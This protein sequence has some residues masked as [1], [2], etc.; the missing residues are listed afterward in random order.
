MVSKGRRAVD[1]PRLNTT[2]ASCTT[3]ARECRRTTGRRRSELR[4]AA[5]Q[6]DASAQYNLGVMYANGEGVPEDYVKAYAWINLA[7]AQGQKDVVKAKD[8]IRE[9][10]TTEQVAGSP[11][12]LRRALQAHRIRKFKVNSPW[13]SDNSQYVNFQRRKIMTNRNAR[14]GQLAFLLLAFACLAMFQPTDAARSK[15]SI[16]SAK[17][18]RREMPRHK[19]SWVSC[20]PRARGCRRTTKRR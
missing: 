7:A 9:K 13:T 5:E 16:S 6:G 12:T 1:S 14:S 20:T 4:K 18:P 15:T 17:P 8:S 2:W 19:T 10:M 3:M 11:E